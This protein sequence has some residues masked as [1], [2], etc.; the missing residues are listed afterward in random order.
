MRWPQVE[1][2]GEAAGPPLEIEPLLAAL[3]E[4]D[5]CVGAL[6]SDASDEYVGISVCREKCAAVVALVREF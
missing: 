2:L 1:C 6:C 3:R 4:L 5:V